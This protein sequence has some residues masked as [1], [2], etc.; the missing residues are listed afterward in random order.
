MS[1]KNT[2]FKRFELIGYS[3][4]VAL[5]IGLTAC[6]AGGDRAGIAGSLSSLSLFAGNTDGVGNIDSTGAAARFY[7]PFGVATDSSGNIYVADRS[8]HVIRKITPAG[9]VSTL[10]G[11]ANNC[12]SVD[13]TGANARFCNP[14]SIATD[15]AGNIFVADRN[16]N[17]I[18]KITPAGVVSTLA[19]SGAASNVNATGTLASFYLPYGVATDSAGNVYVADT[20]NHLIRLITP[21]GVVTTLAGS[22]AASNVNATGTLASFNYPQGVATDS[23]G[24][25]YVA[26]TNNHLIRAIT[27]AGVVTTLAGKANFASNVN[28]TGTLASFNFPQGVAFDSSSGS[29]YVADTNNHTIR[30]IASATAGAASAVVS[31]YAGV[32][33]ASGSADGV[34]TMASFYYP[35]GVATDTAGNVYVADTSNHTIRKI[36]TTGYVSTLAGKP[37]KYGVTNA[38][39]SEARFNGLNDVVADSFGNLYVPDTNNHTIRKISAAGVVST[40]AGKAGVIGSSDGQ[41][42]TALFNYPQGVTMDNNNNLYVS[43]TNNHTIRKIPTSGAFAGVVSTLAGSAG[44]TGFVNGS[45]S[46]VRFYYPKGLAVDSVGNI[47]VADRYNHAIR[48][49][50]PDGVVSTFAGSATGVPGNVDGKGT[51]AGFTYPWGVAADSTGNV[52]VADTDNHT[53]RKITPAGD[54]STLAGAVGITGNADGGGTARFFSPRG[55]VVDPSGNVYVGDTVNH[56]IRKVTPAGIVTTVVGIAGKGD[57]VEGGLPGKLVFPQGIALSGTSLYITSNNGVAVVRNL[58]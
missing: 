54:V 49:I 30:K 10:A 27:P 51:A 31:T 40:F 44:N 1:A 7:Y 4:I 35:E 14:W 12:G 19:G 45:G 16:N 57:F 24:K 55:I 52:Y 21:A 26:D 53:V 22:G 46:T 13:G 50:T 5:L 47:Y 8:N 38:H 58:P 41:G 33:N 15:S 32:T 36:V 39:G 48:K 34:G 2:L 6:G 56:A 17:K 3:A 43:D 20:Y 9:A 42:A 29:L 37:I 28:A 18:R 23:T 11:L 25:V